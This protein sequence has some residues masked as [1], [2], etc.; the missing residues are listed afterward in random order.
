MDTDGKLSFYDEMDAVLGCRDVVT[1]RNVAEAGA[2]ASTSAAKSDATESKDNELLG[3]DTS[4]EA[5]TERKKKRKRARPQE[6]DEEGDLIKASLVGM[7]KQRK[8][9][10]TMM[11][12]MQE[13]QANTMN[14]LVGALTNFLQNS[15]NNNK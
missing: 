4:P 8:E 1:L 5:R 6:G 2:S 13:Q 15:G 11:E 10:N 7:E 14:A 12:R 9:M 3:Q